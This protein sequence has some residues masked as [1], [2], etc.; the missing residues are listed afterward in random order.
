MATLEQTCKSCGNVFTGKFCNQC[1]EKVYTDHDKSLGHI[2]EEGF[3]F[4]THFEGKFLVTLKTLFLQ[5]GK[6]SDDYSFGIRKKYFKPL[7][8]FLMLVVLYLIFPMFRGLNMDLQDHLHNGYYGDF[9][10]E[11]IKAIMA[12]KSWNL[13]QVTDKYHAISAK[14]SKFLLFIIIPVMALFN[15]GVLRKKKR[16]LFDHFIFATETAS[17]FLLWGF[18]L[19]PLLMWPIIKLFVAFEAGHLFHGEAITA[20]L[21]LIPFYFFLTKAGRRFYRFTKIGALAF[22]VAYGS[23]FTIFIL[24]VYKFLLFLISIQFLR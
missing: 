14:V 21:L 5:P 3:H 8:F 17:F 2:L 12:A 13:E 15:W 10:T 16:V 6:L 11:K 1:G 4:I 23:V 24:T 18:L 20:I 7:S 22:S 9:G 19:L